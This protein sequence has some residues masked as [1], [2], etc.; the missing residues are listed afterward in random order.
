MTEAL[1]SP[2]PD[3]FPNMLAVQIDCIR[4]LA[5]AYSAQELALWTEYIEREGP[6]RYMQY[7]NA[8]ITDERGSVRAFVSWAQNAAKQQASVECLYTQH[9]DRGRGFGGLLLQ[10]AER[11]LVPGSVVEVRSTLSAQAFYELHGY[12]SRE[13]ARSRAGFLITIMQKRLP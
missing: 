12:R 5:H 4:G 3:E 2:T 1:R 7:E 13:I 8:V 9:T 10:A 11:A 6:E